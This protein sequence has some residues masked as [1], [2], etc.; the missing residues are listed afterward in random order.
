MTTTLDVLT[1]Q[2][3]T[4]SDLFLSHTRSF[5]HYCC[6]LFSHVDILVSNDVFNF[7]Q[8]LSTANNLKGKEAENKI[9]IYPCQPLN[10]NFEWVFYRKK[11][12]SIFH[13]LEELRKK[14]YS[15]SL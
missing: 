4:S 5:D 10:I 13:F 14:E 15:H 8:I 1:Q 9:I 3:I 7:S 6:C 12:P 11:I 2:I